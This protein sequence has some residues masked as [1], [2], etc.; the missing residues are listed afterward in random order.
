MDSYI[1]RGERT[2][3]ELFKFISNN[4]DEGRLLLNELRR[5][6]SQQLKHQQ[7]LVY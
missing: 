2:L 1:G 4:S 5:I 6:P 7:G 3:L